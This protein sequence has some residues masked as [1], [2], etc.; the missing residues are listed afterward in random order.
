MSVDSPYESEESEMLHHARMLLS[1]LEV[2]NN[3][4]GTNPLVPGSTS[5]LRRIESARGFSASILPNRASK[6]SSLISAPVRKARLNTTSHASRFSSAHFGLNPDTD[7]LWHDYYESGRVMFV[8][9][10]ALDL[11]EKAG[12]IQ[13]DADF[14]IS[15]VQQKGVSEM[16]HEA[17]I[18]QQFID[19]RIDLT[20]RRIFQIYNRFDADQDGGV[21]VAEFR[22]GL[23]QQGFK[24]SNTSI[25]KVIERLKGEIETEEKF[26]EVHI[27]EFSLALQQLKLAEL[28][29]PSVCQATPSWFAY[30]DGSGQKT[31]KSD[32]LTEK[33]SLLSSI[34]TVGFTNDVSKV[35]SRG[36]YFWRTVTVVATPKPDG[37]WIVS[38]VDGPQQ[39]EGQVTLSA[40]EFQ[41]QPGKTTFQFNHYVLA[42]KF[43][44]GF[45]YHDCNM[46][47]VSH[48][49]GDVLCVDETIGM[50]FSM[51]QQEFDYWFQKANRRRV[52]ISCVDYNADDVVVRTPVV[53][54]RSHFFFA[55]RSSEF[56]F[57]H[58][59]R[60][61]HVD[62]LDK[63]TLLRLAV[64]YHLH[65][66]AVEDALE[67]EK[68]PS[69]LDKHGYHYFIALQMA[70]LVS[71]VTSSQEDDDEQEPPPVK[72]VQSHFGMFV[73]G[74]PLFDTVISFVKYSEESLRLLHA[75]ETEPHISDIWKGLRESIC[76]PN[77]KVR[78]FQ[79]DFL[80]FTIIDRC[81][82]CYI[83]VVGA[84]RNRL[85]FFQMRVRHRSGLHSSQLEEISHIRM[86][87]V[88]LQRA[89]KP[90]R[91]VIIHIINDKDFSSDS[92]MYL[93]DVKDHV[94]TITDDLSQLL[95]VCK[96]LFN[97]Y[98]MLSDRK[99]NDTLYVLTIASTIFLPAQ[100]ITGLYGMNFQ[101]EDGRPTIPELTWRY[102]YAYFW[103]TVAVVTFVLV[104]VVKTVNR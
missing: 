35:L 67:I 5:S 66:L 2:S 83:P 57:A 24:L 30:F 55:S 75:P 103:A 84:Y 25:D 74:L 89:V 100:F 70:H 38:T 22:L 46:N 92:T 32:N 7:H 94:D 78:E 13:S 60:W 48:S 47:L 19:S 34:A 40:S 41:L 16:S 52:Y 4:R 68:Q 93:E 11:Q 15:I 29:L 1:L 26:A 33:M 43:E 80:V 64:K 3:T 85:A 79:S 101:D 50:S 39:F 87:L 77:F 86:N 98:N 21:S 61:A 65:P 71:T 42:L 31:S 51:G 23:Q 36:Q 97:D 104:F 72:Y 59:V 18:D 37:D 91:R 95:E 81:V 69:K 27:S 10:L 6:S 44:E 45:E 63:I 99:M 102:G 76:S 96:Q 14:W 20:P 17:E 58:G 82:D 9:E 88:D 49:G 54:V 53:D 73:A 12:R 28:F 90:L 62:A 8:P 56:R